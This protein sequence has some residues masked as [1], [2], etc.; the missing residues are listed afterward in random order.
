M[1][2][3]LFL[4]YDIYRTFVTMQRAKVTATQSSYMQVIFVCCISQ[5]RHTLGLKST[6]NMKCNCCYCWG[7]M[8]SDVWYFI[9]YRWR[10]MK[11]INFMILLVVDHMV[12]SSLWSVQTVFVAQNLSII[13]LLHLL[14]FLLLL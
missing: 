3:C 2:V 7:L 11:L 13:K 6:V 5:K 10:C 8:C 4:V 12:I 1:F 14:L 9:G